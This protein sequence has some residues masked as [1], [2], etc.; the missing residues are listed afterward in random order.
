MP[1]TNNKQQ[2]EE[3]REVYSV[4]RRSTSGEVKHRREE[5]IDSESLA[6]L[7]GRKATPENSYSQSII[8]FAFFT[9]NE[10]NRNRNPI[11]LLYY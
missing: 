9:R 3:S 2:A 1:P 7:V 4:H 10:N 6:R 5:K 11:P 8:F